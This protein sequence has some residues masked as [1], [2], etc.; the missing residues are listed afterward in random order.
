MTY[1]HHPDL[2]SSEKKVLQFQWN[3]TIDGKNHVYM[4]THLI[5]PNTSSDLISI[6]NELFIDGVRK[7]HSSALN[8]VHIPY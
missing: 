7:N 1:D 6:Q 5:T 3:L 2:P 4:I 8:S